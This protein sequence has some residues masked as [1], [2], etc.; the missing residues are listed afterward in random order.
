MEPQSRPE[1]LPP[2]KIR[3]APPRPPS[4]GPARQY[5]KFNTADNAEIYSRSILV[6]KEVGGTRGAGLMIQWMLGVHGNFPPTQV[7]H[8]QGRTELLEEGNF[9]LLL[10][11]LAPVALEPLYIPNLGETSFDLGEL[12]R[13]RETMS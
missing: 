1:N 11:L 3:R 4:K 13:I 2:N 8:L 10:D 7:A 6:M 5:F 12:D 9:A